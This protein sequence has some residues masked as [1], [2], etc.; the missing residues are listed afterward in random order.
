MGSSNGAPIPIFRD[1]QQ[2][3]YKADEFGSIVITKMN[4]SLMQE[5]ANA[6]NGQFISAN[7]SGYISINPIIDRIEKIE[8][9]EFQS[10]KF[11]EWDHHFQYFLGV[12]L[13]VLFVEILLSEKKAKSKYFSKILGIKNQQ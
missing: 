5:I 3:G 2:V 10:M 6:G 7:E 11:K 4:S 1:G 12:A 13:I 9:Q 8:K